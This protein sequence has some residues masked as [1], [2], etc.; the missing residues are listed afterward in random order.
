MMKPDSVLQMI[1]LNQPH[2]V[3]MN[4]T[5]TEFIFYKLSVTTSNCF[6]NWAKVPQFVSLNLT[7]PNAAK[8]KRKIKRWLYVSYRPCR[9]RRTC[10]PRLS[11]ADL[12]PDTAARTGNP[13]CPTDRPPRTA[14]STAG[15]LQ[16]WKSKHWSNISQSKQVRHTVKVLLVLNKNE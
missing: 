10:R 8:K 6:R 3:G 9:A 1:R 14:Q 15:T 13:A 4:W 12:S 11:G 2:I 5:A 7:Q 16:K